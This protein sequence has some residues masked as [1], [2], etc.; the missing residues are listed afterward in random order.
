MT[1][2]LNT[3]LPNV[4]NSFVVP[5]NVH[6]NITQTPSAP[7]PRFLNDLFQWDLNIFGQEEAKGS[8]KAKRKQKR[9]NIRYSILE[10]IMGKAMI[11]K[12][13]MKY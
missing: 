4:V 2:L 9:V 7:S 1:S 11:S 12:L 5:W 10:A 6:E 8:K 3:T 13:T